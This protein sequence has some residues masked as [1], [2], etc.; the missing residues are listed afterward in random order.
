M[1]TL[2]DDFVPV[3][4]EALR[5][6][7]PAGVLAEAKC[8]LPASSGKFRVWTLSAPN[9]SRAV[10]S[11][12]WTVGRAAQ[13]RF[14]YVCDD[15][16]LIGNIEDALFDIHGPPRGPCYRHKDGVDHAVVMMQVQNGPADGVVG[17]LRDIVDS[18]QPVQGKRGR[19]AQVAFWCSPPGISGPFHRSARFGTKS[20]AYDHVAPI[21]IAGDTRLVPKRIFTTAEAA[22]LNGCTVIYF[23]LLSEERTAA[24]A[25]VS[26]RPYIVNIIKGELQVPEAAPEAAPGA[27][28]PHPM[29]VSTEWVI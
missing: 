1:R 26:G 7:V 8:K 29:P 11:W 24:L 23:G 3:P 6:P 5:L 15:S 25:S 12:L 16:T 2:Y 18:H 27:A 10:L 4:H 20:K 19:I 13:H 14:V 22:G 28:Q 17:Q 9:S 21:P